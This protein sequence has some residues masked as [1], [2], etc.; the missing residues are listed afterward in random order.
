MSACP[1][2]TVFD[3]SVVHV[4]R[5]VFRDDLDREAFLLEAQCDRQS[6]DTGTNPAAGEWAGRGCIQE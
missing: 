4:V 1:H 2:A 3:R 5:S 6:D